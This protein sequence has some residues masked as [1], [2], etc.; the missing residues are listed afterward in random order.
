MKSLHV[1][2]TVVLMA[3][4]GG[5]VWVSSSRLTASSSKTR[6]LAA[7]ETLAESQSMMLDSLSAHVRLAQIV[8][9]LP[10]A[11]VICDTD[12]KVIQVDDGF[13]RIT[14]RSQSSLI[15]KH[16]L[17]IIPDEFK[18]R[19]LG[20]GS[21]LESAQPSDKWTTVLSKDGGGIMHLNGTKIPGTV[22]VSKVVVDDGTPYLVMV[23]IADAT[24]VDRG[25]S[26]KA[27][28]EQ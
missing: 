3:L 25:A 14:G 18:E 8:S 4:T 23:F 7:L 15:G 6:T 13:E 27:R 12:F 17:D 16:P 26:F 9:S 24:R 22:R 19:H 11:Y 28:W 5:L 10:S 2:I 21:V 20:P 1:L